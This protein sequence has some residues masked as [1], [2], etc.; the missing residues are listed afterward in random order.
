LEGTRGHERQHLPLVRL[1]EGVE[2]LEVERGARKA[3]DG[4]GG[5]HKGG[6]VAE[7]HGEV[8][9]EG[10]SVAAHGTLEQLW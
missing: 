1:E 9:L 5:A 10:D 3:R 6:G 2:E 8:R 4:G 7:Q